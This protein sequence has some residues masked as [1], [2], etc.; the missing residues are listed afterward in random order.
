MA[1]VKQK[2]VFDGQAAGNYWRILSVSLE[3]LGD[4]SGD[5]A[6]YQSGIGLFAS[7]EKGTEGAA[8]LMIHTVHGEIPAPKLGDD[9]RAFIYDQAKQ[10][11][12][13]IGAEDA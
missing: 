4:S 2:T 6:R 3:F 12:E 10:D 8:P 5:I 1:L 11:P 13:F 9:I 7:A